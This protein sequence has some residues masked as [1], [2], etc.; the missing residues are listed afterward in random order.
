MVKRIAFVVL[1]SVALCKIILAS[2]TRHLKT[3]S[4]LVC[5]VTTTGPWFTTIPLVTD[6]RQGWRDEFQLSSSGR[7]I[8][9]VS[10]IILVICKKNMHADPIFM[11]NASNLL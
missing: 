1:D 5:T 10:K 6:F 4:V 2:I 3:L 9:V 8:C 11:M 7:T